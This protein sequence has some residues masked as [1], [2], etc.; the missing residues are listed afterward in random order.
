MDRQP[1]EQSKSNKYEIKREQKL[2]EQ[3]RRDRNRAVRRTVK[4]VLLATLVVG[5]IGGLTRY[6]ASQPS[7]PVGEIVSSTGIHW[8]PQLSIAIKG[9]KQEIPANIGL[10]AVEQS[11]HTHDATGTLHLEI[12][13]IVKKDDIKLGR[14]FKIWGK[15]FNSSCIFDSCTGKD[16]TLTVLVNGKVNT[17]FDAY[18]MKDG[19]RIEIR[20]E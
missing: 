15:P 5:G 16:G 18:E 6:L 11:L 9:V 10:G 17:E 3:C 13:G 19:D 20:F 12:P 14:F 2:N 8:H 7:I 4:I 1:N